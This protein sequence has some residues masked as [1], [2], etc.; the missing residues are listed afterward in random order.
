MVRMDRNTPLFDPKL[1]DEERAKWLIS[2]MT[3]Q[4]KCDWFTLWI[5]DSMRFTPAA[6]AWTKGRLA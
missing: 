5:R 6:P 3:A 4:E 1:H 2:Q